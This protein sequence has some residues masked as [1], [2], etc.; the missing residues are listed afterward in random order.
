MPPDSGMYSGWFNSAE[1]I[2]APTQ[3]GNFLGIKIGGP[4]H[5][6]HYF[7]PAFAT[8]HSAEENGEPRRKRISIEARGGPLPVPQKTFDWKLIYDPA[9]NSGKGE[10]EVTLGNE[11][12]KLRL[13]DEDKSLG[14]TFDRFGLSS[15]R[16]TSHQKNRTKTPNDRT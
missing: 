13:R 6:G 5:A 7:S 8:A 16:G 14:A 9:G 10:I 12:I 11:T 2:S 3:A 1:R 4:T 15:R